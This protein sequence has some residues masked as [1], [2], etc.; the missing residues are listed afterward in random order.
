MDFENT[1][2]NFLIILYQRYNL[3]KIKF[4]KIKMQKQQIKTN[5]KDKA[6]TW[7]TQVHPQSWVKSNLYTCRIFTNTST[8]HDIVFFLKPSQASTPIILLASSSFSWVFF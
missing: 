4:L 3:F 1:L 8:N 6:H 2:R 7:T 5:K